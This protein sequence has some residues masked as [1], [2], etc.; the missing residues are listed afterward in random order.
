MACRQVARHAS[1][2]LI[3]RDRV[4]LGTFVRH[5]TVHIASTNKYGLIRI[6]CLTYTDVR[7][8][9]Q[10]LPQ[11][12]CTLRPGDHPRRLGQLQGPLRPIP[13]EKWRSSLSR[14]S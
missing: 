14:K 2:L 5:V 1:L 11:V 10:A 7:T 12:W 6:M 4:I 9:K 3:T 13:P 8:R